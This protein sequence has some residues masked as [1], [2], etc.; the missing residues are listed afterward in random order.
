LT[1]MFGTV[2]YHATRETYCISRGTKDGVTLGVSTPFDI[3]EH[4]AHPRFDLRV[5]T[6]SRPYEAEEALL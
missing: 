1:G 2:Q 3:A 6:A 5:K 4:P